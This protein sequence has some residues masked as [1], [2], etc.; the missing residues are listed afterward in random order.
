VSQEV[1]AGWPGLARAQLNDA[2]DLRATIDIR[3]ALKGV[4]R[5]HVG[6][7]A[8]ALHRSVFRIALG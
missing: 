3:A 2:R 1:I 8:S 4:L 6:V 5:D 7:G